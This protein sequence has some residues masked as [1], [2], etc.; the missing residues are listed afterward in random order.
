MPKRLDLGPFVHANPRHL[1]VANGH[2]QVVLVQHLVVLEVVQHGIGDHAGLCCQEDRGAFDAHRR[3]DKH[4]LQKA[5][6][7]DR[8]IT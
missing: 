6:Q 2:K 7:V 8:I 4:R 3:A 5:G 1:V